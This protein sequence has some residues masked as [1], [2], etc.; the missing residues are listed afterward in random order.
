[1][2]TV[3]DAE[4]RLARDA[5]AA[6]HEPVRA[7]DGG[8]AT[9]VF[10]RGVVVLLGAAAT[11]AGVAGIHAASWLIGPLLL[12]FVIVLAVSPIQGWLRRRGW[13]AWAATLSLL[14]VIYGALLVLAVFLVASVSQLATVLTQNAG[15]S[16]QLVAS[17]RAALTD[18]GIDPT[19][20]AHVAGTADL[21]K[22]VPAVEGLVSGVGSVLAGLVLVLALLLFLTAESA[23]A[24]RR[25]RM[26]GDERPQVVSALEGFVHGTRN[27][28]VVTAVFGLIVA[29]LDGAALAIM[30][31]PLA[32]LWAVLSF[33]TN[34]I[35]NV[36]FIVGLVPPAL[37]ALVTGGWQSALAVVAVYCVLNLVIQSLIQPHFIGDSVGL[38]TTVTFVA[39]LFWAWILGALGA[40][41]AIPLTLLIKAV[42]VDADPRARWVEALVGSDPPVVEAA[43][44]PAGP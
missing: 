38:S 18:V 25:M 4:H 39:L 12:A 33:L 28:L 20:S 14:V 27:Y 37:L 41:L 30:G 35:P 6:A 42:L 40:L 5:E 15:A 44:A 7:P 22:V 43:P 32:L 31:V 26:I 3:S 10:P 2:S 17:L 11:V 21:S 13:P 34:F 36:G 16:Q 1:V 24:A 29:V 23:G 9:A 19:L 8:G